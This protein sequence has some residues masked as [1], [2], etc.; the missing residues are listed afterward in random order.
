MDKTYFVLHLR[1]IKTMVGGKEVIKHNLRKKDNLEEFIDKTKSHYNN[2]SGATEENFFVVYERLVAHLPRKIQK[3]ASRLIEFVVS[4]S[5]EY[6]EG[7]KDNPELKKKIEDYFNEAEQFLKRRYGDFII[8]RANHYDEFT[9]HCHILLVPL[10]RKKDGGIKFSSSEFLGGIKGLFDLHDK[11]YKEV[12][13][14]Y[15]LERGIR[16]GRTK[17][18]NLKSYEE[19]EKEQRKLIEDKKKEADDNLV[20]IRQQQIENQRLHEQMMQQSEKL[21]KKDKEVKSLKERLFEMSGNALKKLDDLLTQEREYEELKKKID[22]E[23]IPQIPIPPVAVSENSRK[24]WRDG[25]Q[26]L[27]DE[28]FRKLAAGIHFIQ[29]KHEVLLKNYQSLLNLNKVYKERADKAEKDLLEKPIEE[30]VADRKQKANKV[31]EQQE[32]DERGGASR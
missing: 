27:I 1:K 8:C 15:S 29:E 32:S 10:C 21:A 31:Q 4:F 17:H 5:H 6:G 28:T 12:G 16:N 7:W 2:Y 26:S 24:T 25:I 19:W 22:A 14:F 11:F 3:N 13:I 9:P 20:I 23:P 18:K 30:I